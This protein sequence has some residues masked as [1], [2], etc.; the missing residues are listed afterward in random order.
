VIIAPDCCGSGWPR[1]SLICATHLER[2]RASA[3]PRPWLT[4]NTC[5]SGWRT[6][7]SRTFRHVRRRP[8]HL[9]SLREAVLV[10][11][12]HVGD[13]HRHPRLCLPSR[14]RPDRRSSGRASPAPAL[15]V[16]T[17]KISHAPEQTTANVGGSLSP[18]PLPSP[19]SRTRRS[20]LD[21]RDVQNGIES[22]N[23]HS[24]ILGP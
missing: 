24:A 15:A 4:R 5:P 7:I 12:V 18:M 19:A 21:V 11:G 20:S 6:C 3:Q 13:P 1:T 14:R 2:K 16:L 17:E 23:E 22:M 8:R 9:E 10:D